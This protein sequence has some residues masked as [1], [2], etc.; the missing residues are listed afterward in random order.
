LTK[1]TVLLIYLFERPIL[2]NPV[3]QSENTGNNKKYL[4][5]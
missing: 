3:Q 4:R 1:N 2:S 5:T